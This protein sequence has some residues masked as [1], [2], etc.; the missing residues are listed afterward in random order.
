[1]KIVPMKTP[2]PLQESE[3]AHQWV[4]TLSFL[5][6]NSCLSDPLPEEILDTT[7]V[8]VAVGMMTT[9]GVANY[10]C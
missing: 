8:P 3:V 2:S 6:V 5:E 7:P 4:P 10:E 1:M 9:L